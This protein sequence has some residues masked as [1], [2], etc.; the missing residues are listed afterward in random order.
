MKTLAKVHNKRHSALQRLCIIYNNAT[1][2]SF[3]NWREYM[4][5]CHRDDVFGIMRAQNSVPS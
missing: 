2:H 4:M 3:V 1:K 5:K